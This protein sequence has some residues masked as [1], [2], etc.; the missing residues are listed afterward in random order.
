MKHLKIIIFFN[1]KKGLDIY[2]KIKK[3]YFFLKIVLSQKNLN[4]DVLKMLEK[5]KRKNY[6]N[7]KIW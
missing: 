6:S 3:K 4:Y 2:K 5:K 1:N 7:Q